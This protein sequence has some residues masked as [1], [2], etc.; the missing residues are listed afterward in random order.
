MKNE[1]V[2][3]KEAAALKELGFKELCFAQYGKTEKDIQLEIWNDENYTKWESLC[4]APTYSQAFRWFR[5]KHKLDSVIVPNGDSSGKTN[6][7]YYELIF[8]FSK[9]NIESES[10]STY[11]KAELECIKELIEIV[12]NKNK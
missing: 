5:K 8:D 2:P 9:D 6:G 12:K 4:G 7:Y 1:L 10:Y 11:E 3:Y